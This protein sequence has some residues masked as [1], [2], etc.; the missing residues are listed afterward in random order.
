ML[1]GL[2][3]LAPAGIAGALALAFAHGLVAAL[4]GALETTPR[5][6]GAVV[7]ALAASLGAPGLAP[8]AGLAF[9]V[10]DAAPRHPSVAIALLL[11]FAILTGAH[12]RLGA[13]LVST[14][15]AADDPP[16]AVARR[17]RTLSSS[18]RSPRSCSRSASCRRRSSRRS[19]PARS[20]S[21]TSP[22]V[23]GSTSRDTAVEPARARWQHRLPHACHTRTS[24]RA[25][26]NRRLRCRR[27]P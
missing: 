26:S 25:L 1:I 6:R 23:S 4:L 16:D 18:R 21:R 5:A 11:G 7:G 3:S 13:R 20:T 12:A 24:R 27:D 8:F 14:A 17:R 10:F 9:I 22:R 2:A 15:P 19:R